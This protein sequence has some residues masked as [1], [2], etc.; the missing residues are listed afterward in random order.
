VKKLKNKQHAPGQKKLTKVK[1]KEGR[2]PGP[3]KGGFRS[4]GLSTLTKEREKRRGG[5]AQLRAAGFQGGDSEEGIQSNEEKNN[6]KNVFPPEGDESEKDS[7][8]GRGRRNLNQILDKTFLTG[9][10]SLLRLWKT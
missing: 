6:S 10:K 9:R 8:K 7:L 4:N 5:K 2:H 1:L 3:R